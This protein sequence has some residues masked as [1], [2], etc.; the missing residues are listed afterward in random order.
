MLFPNLTTNQL[1][2][3]AEIINKQLESILEKAFQTLAIQPRIKQARENFPEH[4]YILAI[5]TALKQRGMIDEI[6]N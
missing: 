2:E 5:R 6:K 1:R 4:T 3:K